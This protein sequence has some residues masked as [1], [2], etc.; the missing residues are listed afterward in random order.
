[1][2]LR[3]LHSGDV[4]CAQCSYVMHCSVCIEPGNPHLRIVC[5]NPHCSQVGRIG[6]V[7]YVEVSEPLKGEIRADGA[8]PLN[9][10][11]QTVVPIVDSDPDWKL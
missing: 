2:T 11:I 5:R 9:P 6:I 4:I 8:T 7:P 10:K 1:M 3:V